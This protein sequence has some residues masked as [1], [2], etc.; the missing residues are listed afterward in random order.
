MATP[1]QI[2]ANRANAQSSTGPRTREGKAASSQ[3]A[4]SHGLTTCDLVVKSG[5]KDE[6]TQFTQDIWDEVQP[7]GV[8]EAVLCRGLIHAA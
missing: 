4:L 2:A 6:F 8:I 5:E 7:L 1:A 3:N